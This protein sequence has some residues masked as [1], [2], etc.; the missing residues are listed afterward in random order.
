MR[1]GGGTFPVRGWGNL[2]I[3]LLAALAGEK[4]VT[5][6]W[7]DEGDLPYVGE[8]SKAFGL[9][10]LVFGRQDS[11]RGGIRLEVLIGR[12]PAD[13]KAC[14]DIWHVPGKNPGGLLGYPSCCVDEYWKWHKRHPNCDEPDYV[15]II[16]WAFDRTSPRPERIP[17]LINNV[18]YLYSRRWATSGPAKREEI[19]R[20]NPGLDMDVM[21][22]VPW[23]SC[24]YDCPESIRKAK[25]VW[26][27][28]LKTA[29]KLAAMLKTCLARPVLFWEWP[30]FAVLKG[31][32]DD[33]GGFVYE[34]VQPPFSLLEP[35]L[36][37]L[38][39]RG[40]R[41]RADG[42][43]RAALFDAAGKELALPGER[44]LL[45]GFS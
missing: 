16:T 7:I 40:V 26:L 5:H 1:P 36:L 9:G 34:G 27:T 21:N 10:H 43:G 8:L 39:K 6:C 18:L 23:H 20:R 14:A 25:A 35:E 33:A 19:F 42:D 45:L 30:R 2:P 12:D 31:K 4:P 44:P 32:P 29:P 11:E 3:E 37:A 24:R 28:A 22:V 38:V 15:D 13:L 41:A 17:F